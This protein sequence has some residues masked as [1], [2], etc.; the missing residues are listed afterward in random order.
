MADRDK[1]F[2]KLIK[3]ELGITFSTQNNSW[4]DYEGME[5]YAYA[6]YDGNYLINSRGKALFK[7]E[8]K[9][10]EECV[11]KLKKN[12]DKYKAKF[13]KYAAKADQDFNNTNAILKSL[14]N[15]NVK[16]ELRFDG[17]NLTIRTGK[18]PN[19]VDYILGCLESYEN[20]PMVKL[21][22]K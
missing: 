15:T 4:F 21:I 14:N 3:K 16:A 7:I 12:K 18:D 22:Y 5:L 1:E 20:D 8:A 17:Q 10:A 13:D 2:K 6:G 9:T 19:L 11:A